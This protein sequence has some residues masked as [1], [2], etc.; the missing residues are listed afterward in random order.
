LPA[1]K[2]ALSISRSRRSAANFHARQL[3]QPL[4]RSDAGRA[5]SPFGAFPDRVADCA[6]AIEE[7]ARLR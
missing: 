4:E 2:A 7:K 5:D 6:R 3:P 1:V